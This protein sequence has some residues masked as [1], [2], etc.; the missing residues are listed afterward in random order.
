[1][2]NFLQIEMNKVTLKHLHKNGER[3]SAVQDIKVE[4][5]IIAV[6]LTQDFMGPS[7]LEK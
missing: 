4:N 3:I 7:S 5:L 1:M 6:S 2:R